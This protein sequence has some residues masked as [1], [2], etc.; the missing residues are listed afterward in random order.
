LVPQDPEDEP[1]SKLLEHI[2]EEK[3]R[4]YKEG[5]IKKPKKLPE[6]EEEEK[7]VEL[8][9]G[10]EWVRLGD[11]GQIVGGG[12]PKSG[13][14]SFWTEDGV[15]WLTP[16]DLYGFDQKYISSGRRD[17]S[18]EGLERS[19]ATLMPKGSV[20]FSSRAPI[21]YV[22]IAG[23]PLS[24]NQGF[25]S[26]VP[27]VEGMSE[28]LFYFLKRSGQLIN[29]AASGTTFKEISGSKMAQVLVALPPQNEQDRIV[30]KVD[31]LMTLC[32]RLEQQTS[33]QINAHETLVDTLLDT[34][35]RS[36]DASELAN[37]WDRLA[38]HYDTLFTTEHSIDR[39]EQTILQLA[40]M[41]CLAPQGPNDE[42]ASKLLERIEEEKAQLIKEGKRKK[43]KPL[44][45]IA[46][47][48]TP[49]EVPVGWKWERFDAI[50]VDGPTNGWSPKTVEYDTGLC[51]LT[52]SATTKGRFDGSHS[53]FVEADLN[54]DSPLWL[55]PGDVLIQRS[56]TPE[57]V[58]M[59]AVYDGPE[60]GFIYPDLMMRCRVSQNIS[61][62]FFQI[63][64]NAPFNRRRL[65]QQA[66]GTSRSMVKIN[67]T[68]VRSTPI[69]IPPRAEQ[70]RI[71]ERFKKLKTL[72]DYLKSRLNQARESQKSLADSLVK[73]AVN[74]M[75]PHS[76]GSRH[77]FQA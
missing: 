63:V 73:R 49:F 40:V 13:E 4:L 21:G 56:N 46:T 12:T 64:W 10:W 70:E 72:C 39:L 68:T 58:G 67:Q 28:Y 6:I 3:R 26:C 31:E 75:V 9:L 22:A 25:K 43:L 41:G 33:D 20:L 7:Q 44:S 32:D 59:A 76:V 2:E 16:A 18:W 42:P 52:L 38:E 53:K 37:N 17:I 60:R 29:E 45:P 66:S 15:K 19:S 23:G 34:L 57:Y 11:I 8:P 50:L 30:E 77:F 24:T 71:V 54:K 74:G 65:S 55:F 61:V 27:Y 47:E 48:E 69:P 1:A 35:T 62:E 5:K 51:T 36:H 14:P